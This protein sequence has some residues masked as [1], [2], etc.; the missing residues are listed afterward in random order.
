MQ[1]LA[2]CTSCLCMEKEVGF[3]V[4]LNLY[5]QK[6]WKHEGKVKQMCSLG[7]YK[8]FWLLT[9]KFVFQLLLPC[10]SWELSV[11]FFSTWIYCLWRR[12]NLLREVYEQIGSYCE[13]LEGSN[14][15]F[16]WF[17]NGFHGDISLDFEQ[18]DDSERDEVWKY[19]PYHTRLKSNGH[20]GWEP[21]I[22]D[23][24]LAGKNNIGVI[25]LGFKSK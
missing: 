16:Q 18:E 12:L 25:K 6:M 22:L 3:V 7:L 23:L 20:S 13:I 14:S 24:S 19:T 5:R 10:S 17:W 11:V 2:K 4:K 8:D 9:S 21:Q 1:G 15:W